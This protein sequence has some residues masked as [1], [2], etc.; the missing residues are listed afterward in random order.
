MGVTYL[1]SYD[2]GFN[3][4]YF[5]TLLFRKISYSQETTK[6][7]ILIGDS[8][9]DR[10]CPLLRNVLCVMATFIFLNL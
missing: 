9:G 6:S 3:V 10:I 4:Y 8:I 7:S 1:M 2:V 5:E